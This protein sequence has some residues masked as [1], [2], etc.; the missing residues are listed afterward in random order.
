MPLPSLIGLS[1]HRPRRLPAIAE[2][3][4]SACGEK[5]PNWTRWGSLKGKDK[6][7]LLH[8]VAHECSNSSGRGGVGGIYVDAYDE[9]DIDLIIELEQ[10][11]VEHVVARSKINGS[12]PGDGEDDPLGWVE[13]TRSANSRRSNHPLV[14]WPL[15]PNSIPLGDFVTF[16]GVKHYV[17]PESQRARLARKWAFVRA[18]YPGEVSAVSA[19]QRENMPLIVSMMKS[20]QPFPSEL[21]VNAHFRDEYGW[22]NPLLEPNAN[23]W[24]DDPVFRGLITGVW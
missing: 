4:R 24:L 12:E 16:H 9:V 1:F 2:A 7:E 21:C 23:K 6:N 17:P 13:A 11:S 10:W 14:L 8:D 20:T 19:A 5:R 15:P 22:S 3:W 18:T